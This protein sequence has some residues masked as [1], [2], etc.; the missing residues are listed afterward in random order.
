MELAI[1]LA[2]SAVYIPSPLLLSLEF[3]SRVWVILPL[4]S[5]FP[6]PPTFDDDTR[7][8]LRQQSTAR[9]KADVSTNFQRARKDRQL[10]LSA[11]WPLLH[12]RRSHNSI[13]RAPIKCSSGLIYPTIF[14]NRQLATMP[15]SFRPCRVRYDSDSSLDSTLRLYWLAFVIYLIIALFFGAEYEDAFVAL[16]L[17]MD[18]YQRP[19]V[20]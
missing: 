9:Q 11:R 8:H 2:A 15:A 4:F 6:C 5:L 12:H 7:K 16:S 14:D 20:Q 13:Q 3:A 1:L 10:A 19:C 18:A 17:I